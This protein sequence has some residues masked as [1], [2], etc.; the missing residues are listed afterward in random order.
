[1]CTIRTKRKGNDDDGGGGSYGEV[2]FIDTIPMENRFIP[3]KVL[4]IPLKAM[5]LHPHRGSQTEQTVI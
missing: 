2:N 1:M 3:A 5:P 4:H